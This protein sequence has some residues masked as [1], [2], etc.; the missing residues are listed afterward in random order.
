MMCK[1]DKL[2]W[3]DVMIW[4]AGILTGVVIVVSALATVWWIQSL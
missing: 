3:I 4:I 1:R 2:P